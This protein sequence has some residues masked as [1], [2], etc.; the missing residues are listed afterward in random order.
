MFSP[1]DAI[2]ALLELEPLERN[3]YRGRNRDIGSGRI[4]G[5]QV[6]GQALVAARHTIEEED[7]EAHSLHGYFILEG[8]LSIPGRLLRRPHARRQELRHPARHRDPARPRDLHAV[9]VVSPY[10]DRPV[11][12]VRNARCS[13]PR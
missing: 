7:R 8:D 5:G 1:S 11:A 6:L 13:A 2:T 4:F 12:P 3:I 10:G 9:R